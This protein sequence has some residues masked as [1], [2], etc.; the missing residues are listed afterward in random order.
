MRRCF[1][2]QPVKSAKS[3]LCRCG[4]V[5]WNGD[6]RHRCEV[7]D[8]GLLWRSSLREALHSALWVVRLHRNRIIVPCLDYEFLAY[9]SLSFYSSF[10]FLS[11]FPIRFFLEYMMK[12]LG[13][14]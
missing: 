13:K 9:F 10:S 11:F 6:T 3:D 8:V 14:K 1:I 12:Q 5:T 7:G 4:G 2:P